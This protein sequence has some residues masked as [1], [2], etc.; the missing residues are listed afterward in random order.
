[1]RMSK[2]VQETRESVHLPIWMRVLAIVVGVISIGAGLVAFLF[3][4]VAVETLA[5]LFSIALV[6]LG[7]ERLAVGISGK[8]YRV[9][10]HRLQKPTKKQ[11]EAPL[12]S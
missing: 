7:V 12:T 4:L 6:I 10:T 1:M 2:M 5:L 9:V 11:V 8:T 3:P